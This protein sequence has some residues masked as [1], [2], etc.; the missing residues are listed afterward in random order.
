MS[1]SDGDDD[2]VFDRMDLWARYTPKTLDERVSDRT[3]VSSKYIWSV[4]IF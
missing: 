2:E 4:I 1:M 3:I